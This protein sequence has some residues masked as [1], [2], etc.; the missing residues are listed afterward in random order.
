MGERFAKKLG[1]LEEIVGVLERFRGGPL[2][3]LGQLDLIFHTTN[4]CR[5]RGQPITRDGGVGPKRQSAAAATVAGY[6][7]LG[8]VDT[9]AETAGEGRNVSYTFRRA[10]ETNAFHQFPLIGAS[11]LRSE[12]DERGVRVPLSPLDELERLDREGA[13]SPI[14]F[15]TAGVDGESVVF[16]DEHGFVAWTEYAVS[17]DVVEKPRPHYS[18]WQLLYLNAAVELPTANVSIDWLLDDERRQTVNPIMRDWWGR[19]LDR[20]RVLERDWRDLLLVLIR[21]QSRYGPSVK[22]TLTKSTVT[23]IRHP[24]TGEYVDPRELEPRLDAEGVCAE[25]GVSLDE[26]KAMHDRL[27]WH[28]MR[29]D[30]LEN[31]H[32]LFRMAPFKQRARL[33]G[34]ARRAQDA[35]DAAEML[36]RFY[37]DLTGE[38]LLAPD[39]QYDGSD[40]S[41]KRKLFGRWPMLR[42]T[43]A[44]LAVELRLRQLHPHEVHLAVEGETEFAICRRVLEELGA[45]SLSEMGVTMQR[46]HGVGGLRLSR[47]S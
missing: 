22:G 47:S 35:Y 12:A 30:P 11:K 46:L 9:G 18:P 36:R 6:V 34:E 3:L 26:L 28:G 43:R 1:G 2:R 27:V 21:L 33:R 45:M 19:Q 38:L 41:W 13:F 23:L 16:R 17:D 20:W 24:E 8:G 10:Y 39:D 42:Y 37:Y 40:K 5:L 14:L 29:A 44:D 15:E 7:Y 32:M 4:S 25:L 31:W